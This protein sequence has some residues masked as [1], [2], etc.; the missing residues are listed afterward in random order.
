SR[1]PDLLGS[2]RGF[3]VA[4]EE[5]LAAALRAA[6]KNTESFSILDVH[7]DPRD[8]SPALEQL[9]SSL[10]KRVRYDLRSASVRR[11]APPWFATRRQV[12]QA[13]LLQLVPLFLL[14]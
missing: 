5:Q 4:T 11:I 13:C 14:R 10:A 3:D 8:M 2:G 9:T 12:R 7:L 1:I 6:R